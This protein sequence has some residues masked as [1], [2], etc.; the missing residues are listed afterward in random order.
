MGASTNLQL[1]DPRLPGLPGEPPLP[2][3]IAE[4]CGGA[5]GAP[6]FVE[7]CST[8]AGTSSGSD[9]VLGW[10]QALWNPGIEGLR[11]WETMERSGSLPLLFPC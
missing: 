4:N 3:R 6:D 10:T 7:L 2:S 11:L 1:A 8:C 9:V 5:A